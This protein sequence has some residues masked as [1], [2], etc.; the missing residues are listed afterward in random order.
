MCSTLLSVLVWCPG[1]PGDAG[2]QLPRL[3]GQASCQQREDHSGRSIEALSAPV[4]KLS[5]SL[6][7]KKLVEVILSSSFDACPVSF[8]SDIF[9]MIWRFLP[10]LDP[11]VMVM[12]SRDLGELNEYY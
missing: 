9:G 1:E 11:S 5:V 6:R 10:L 4:F 8:Y 7:R 3:A 2:D 12:V